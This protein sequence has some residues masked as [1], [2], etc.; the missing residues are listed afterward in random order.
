MRRRFRFNARAIVAVMLVMFSTSLTGTAWA[1]V[2][3]S[4][5]LTPGEAAK[6]AKSAPVKVED[7]GCWTALA[8]TCYTDFLPRNG[9]ASPSRPMP[10]SVSIFA[11][12]SDAAAVDDFRSR[13]VGPT[14]GESSDDSI[15]VLSQSDDSIAMLVHDPSKRLGWSGVAS[16]RA[17]SRIIVA[18]CNFGA[19][20]SEQAPAAVTP[21]IRTAMSRCMEGLA[22]AQVKKASR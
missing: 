6:A 4:S 20:A 2:Q 7:S 10:S 13:I 19:S 17:G 12:A 16:I 21:R 9:S 11:H 14:R 8:A 3:A 18:G 22:T 5:L 15:V 1:D